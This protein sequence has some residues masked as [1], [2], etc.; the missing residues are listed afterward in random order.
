MT[1]GERHGQAHLQSQ[2]YAN[3]DEVCLSSFSILICTAFTAKS[4]QMMNYESLNCTLPN[5]GKTEILYCKVDSFQP[6][7]TKICY[8]IFILQ[9]ICLSRFRI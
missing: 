3:Y 2:V 8:V 5:D 1:N 7:E 9:K 4:I 6:C